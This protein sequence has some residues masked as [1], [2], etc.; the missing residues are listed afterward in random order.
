MAVELGVNVITNPTGDTLPLIIEPSNPESS[1]V[2]FLKE[3]VTDNTD[4]IS[5]YLTK[6]GTRAPP[7]WYYFMPLTGA[8]LFRGFPIEKGIHFQ[9]VVQSYDDLS[10]EYR[11]TSPRTLIPGT[12]VHRIFVLFSLFSSLL[13]FAVCFFR[14]WASPVLSHTTTHWNVLPPRT[15]SSPL[16]L[17]SGGTHVPWGGDLTL[18]LQV[19]QN[20]LKDRKS[21]V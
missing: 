21:V 19:R 16:L 8:I 3:W 10:D 12:Q 15:S 6:Y 20:L 4:T 13:L 2:E 17:L 7:V 5:N 14:Q 18:W 9:E 1:T 11:G